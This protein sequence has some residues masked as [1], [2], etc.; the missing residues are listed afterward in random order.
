MSLQED[1][2][3]GDEKALLAKKLL[4]EACEKEGL[5]SMYWLPKLSETLGVKSRE[6][7]K[8]LEYE[9]YLKL[10]CEVRY[11]WETKALWKLLELTDNKATSEELQKECLEMTKQR[12]EEAKL[13][14]KELK[15]MHNSR[16]LSKDVLRQKEEALW[17]A[18]EIP[19]EYWAPLEK[20]LEGV[21]ESI[22]K[23]LEQQESLVSSGQNVSD[24]EVLRRASGGL[25]LQGIY[26]TSSLTDVL[27]RRE[28]L[29]RA[30]EGFKLSGPEQG[31]LLERKEFSSSAAEAAF[32]K[33]MEQL[34][35][36]ISVSAKAGF[37]GFHAEAGVD[38]SSSSQ[39][40]NIHQSRSDQSYL[41]TTKYQY[42]P[43]ASC[44]FQKHQ[45]RLSD[46][47]L[48]ELQVIEHLLS[49]TQEADRP[50][51][52]KSRCE[53]FFG[54]FGSHV[55]QGPIHF[56]GIF[57]WKASIEGFRA[58]QREEVRQQASEALNSYIEASYK[59]FGVSLG[60]DID[61]SKSSL[62]ASLERKDKSSAQREVQLCVVNT[63]GPSETPSLPQWKMG[64]VAN[65]KTWCVIDRGFQLIPV[66]DVILFN[67][68]SDFKSIYQMSSSLRAAYEALTDHSVGSV[69]GEELLSAVEEARAFMEYVK[70]WEVAVDEKK[71]L[72]LI[73]VKQNLNEKTQNHSVWINVCQ[74]VY[75]PNWVC[76]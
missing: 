43:L 30:P 42:I 22:Q 57:W 36:S 29:I 44:Y 35:F 75:P 5:D 69:F 66:W 4:A 76:M 40:E 61:V 3:E 6:A 53:S 52:L 16:S 24:V 32:T 54:R 1:I 13:V 23:H 26:Q 25:A 63:G 73:D 74:C 21:L 50:N 38:Y 14:L 7:L 72:T 28:Q 47:A 67:H 59:G 65:N 68:S 41:C 34:G 37:W 46:A 10:E 18:M 71:L 9:D 33:S 39:T 19:K 48:Q 20:S 17:K 60:V 45:L 12:Q 2:L 51:M 58:E 56:G 31:S 15:E 27:A 8:H 64:L 55:N 11:P 62:Q 49:I 70:T